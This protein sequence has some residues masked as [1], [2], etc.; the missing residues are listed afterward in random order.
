MLNPPPR[1]AAPVVL[2]SLLAGAPPLALGGCS[3]PGAG[4]PS[5]APRPIESLSL[6]EPATPPAPAQVADPA[7]VARYAPL[8]AQAHSAD[9]AFRRALEQGRAALAAGRNA[10]TGSE[11]WAEAQ[12]ALSRIETAREPVAKA[13]ADLDAARNADPTHASTGEA[14]AAAQAFDQ[15]QQ[16]DA[17]E[18]KALGE[19]W[20]GAGKGQ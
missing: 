8:I 7:A 3:D 1:R 6:A 17:A 14:I 20:P 2:L 19:A 9:E 15:V 16:I 4:Y 12:V 13:L 5:L 10:A 18:T 11:P